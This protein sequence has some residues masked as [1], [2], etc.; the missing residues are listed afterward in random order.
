MDMFLVKFFPKVFRKMQKAQTN[1]YCKFDSQLL[2]TF[3]SSLYIA[4]LIASFFASSCTRV[5]GRKVS[6]LF[7]G[8]I[9]LVSAALNGAA[10][11]VPMLIVGHILLDIG[12]GF[13]NQ[14][15][16]FLKENYL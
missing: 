13:A 4:A 2:T 7:G 6:M 1:D 12:V 16:N 9:F 11:N 14:V 5:L 15:C 8:A 10:M 3:T